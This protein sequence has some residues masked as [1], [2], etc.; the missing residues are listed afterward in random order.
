MS[1]PWRSEPPLLLSTASVPASRPTGQVVTAKAGPMRSGSSDSLES[2]GSG[3]SI[4]DHENSSLKACE[5]AVRRP[6]S[7]AGAFTCAPNDGCV[8]PAPAPVLSIPPQMY[9]WRALGQYE[10]R[11]RPSILQERTLSTPA[12][13][14]SPPKVH[15]LSGSNSVPILSRNPSAL[16][17]STNLP[18][19]SRGWQHLRHPVTKELNRRISLPLA[20]S[21]IPS[22][23][24]VANG[25]RQL[26][27]TT[28]H[29]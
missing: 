11:I 10:H 22:P 4:P 14:M 2:L 20:H 3:E 16:P 19:T 24:P 26:G 15:R 17:H 5:R 18:T 9:G 27:G 25:H 28:L 8:R 29:Q 7:S 13:F 23:S 12:S 6:P 1:Y 21:H